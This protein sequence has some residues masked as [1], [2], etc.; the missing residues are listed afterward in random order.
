MV[1]KKQ[2]ALVLYSGGLDSRLVV[3]FLQE[4]D[5]E[6]E[7]LHFNLPFGC[8]CCDLN[9]NFKFTQMSGAKLTILD[10][11]K[12]DLVKEY[13][14]IM[15]KPKFG[16][17]AGVNPCRDC[18]IFMFKK[19][20]EYADKKKIK[21]IATGEVTSQRPMSQTPG[22]MKLI[23]EQIGFKL[24]RPL[25]ELGIKG[26]RRDKQIKLAKKFGIK[27]PSPGGGCLLCEKGL[28]KKF[29]VLF[30]ENLINGKTLGLV[31]IG[32]HFF[33]NG[34]WF[35]VARDKAECEAIEEFNCFVEGVSGKPAVHYNLKK[36]LKTAK[37]LQEV[38]RTGAKESE[39]KKFGE[40]KL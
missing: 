3:K 21:V 16:T 2:K 28:Q 10:C 24:T 12:G 37:E 31:N 30:K 8:G 15:K 19:A 5:Y 4:K 14:G 22:A 1:K 36:G 38:F 20:K 17:G 23:D 40:W 35:V 29:G 27:Y 26:R 11:C 13:L 6:V 39:R 9:C 32:R 33:K 34:V 7:A 25:I 18:K